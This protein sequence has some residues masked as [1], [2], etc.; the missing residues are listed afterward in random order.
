MNTKDLQVFTTTYK[1]NSFSQAAAKIYMSPQGV[2]KTITKLETELG[3]QLFDRTKQ[4]IEPTTSARMLYEKSTDLRVIFQSISMADSENN[5]HQEMINL[6]IADDFSSYLG[7]DFFYNFQLENHNKTLNFVEFPDSMLNK[8]LISHGNIGFIEGPIDFKKFDGIYFDTNY[9]CAIMSPKNPLAVGDK[10]NIQDLNHESLATKSKEFQIFNAH[11]SEL[12]KHHV[13]PI[14]TLQTSNNDFIVEFARRNLGIGI[15]PN[16]LMSLPHFKDLAEKGE[17]VQK[18]LN[19]AELKRDIYFVQV[20]GKELTAGE[21]MFKD[22][23]VN[24]LE[25]KE[26]HWRCNF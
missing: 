19:G 11:L 21:Q 18:Q 10:V 1:S 6:F 22:Y 9:Y 7:F 20:K 24:Y 4:G 3:V 14:H 25:N 2:S 15:V 26:N 5:L 8:A 17:V 16:Y 23:V 13:F 12:V